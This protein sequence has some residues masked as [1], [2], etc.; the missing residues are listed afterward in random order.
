MELDKAYLIKQYDNYI[1]DV[2]KLQES[3]NKDCLSKYPVYPY[4]KEGDII[5]VKN[6]KNTWDKLNDF[7]NFDVY[8]IT[9]INTPDMFNGNTDVMFLRY[10]FSI[11]FSY[12]YE[13]VK[14][15]KSYQFSKKQEDIFISNYYQVE[16]FTK[17]K[18]TL[19][20]DSFENW[21]TC[22]LREIDFISLCADVNNILDKINNE[23]VSEQ[24]KRYAKQSHISKSVLEN[25]P[26]LVYIHEKIETLKK[27]QTHIKTK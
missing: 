13:G 22:S 7:G 18:I 26:E 21:E 12:T 3:Y 20:N 23:R 8:K 16:M 24:L 9:K 19:K 1:G 25:N 15:L 11:D 4:F 6:R 14:L 17:D 10:N 27:F 5:K 2:K